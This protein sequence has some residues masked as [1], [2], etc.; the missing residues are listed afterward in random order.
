MNS[1]KGFTLIELLG[2][3]ILLAII[4]LI[5]SP[6]ITGL[7]KKAS[8]NESNRFINDIYLATE[9]YIQTNQ[10]NYE[11]LQEDGGIAF[12]G[13]KELVNSG[14]LKSTLYD[15]T[16]K[17]TIKDELNF[18]VKVT[19]MDFNLSYI[20]ISDDYT[21]GSY[22]Q[23]GLVLLYDGYKKPI[24][25][26]GQK[27]WRD[28]SGNSA[29]GIINGNIEWDRNRLTF[30]GSSYVESISSSDEFLTIE[31]VSVWRN[32]FKGS[33]VSNAKS[34][35]YGFH[36]FSKTD[37][38]DCGSS[39]S[40][41]AQVGTLET[42]WNWEYINLNQKVETD[43]IYRSYFIVDG[44]NITVGQNDLKRTVAVSTSS[45]G[46]RLSD[47]KM[48]IGSGVEGEIYAVRI[49]NRALTE[50]EINKNYQIDKKRFGF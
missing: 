32:S 6:K 14:F 1:K 29:D 46:V 11:E 8:D 2:V 40:L 9:A 43:K 22:V 39:E 24:S 34:G 41:C 19:N 31:V 12:I 20:I 44:K 35:G 10:Q 37:N 5:S 45:Y 23:D 49:Y 48:K 36:L 38:A 21:T 15:P 33:L 17:K 27:V 50:D 28:L 7:L 47:S 3:I 30:D 18:T 25:Q 4:I 13:F 16:T 26:D 42:S